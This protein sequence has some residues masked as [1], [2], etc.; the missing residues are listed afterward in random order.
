MTGSE[1]STLQQ[2]LFPSGSPTEDISRSQLLEQYKIFVQTSEA[3]VSRRQTV[4]AF[5][6]SLNTLLL[7]VIGFL[8]KEGVSNIYGGLGVIVMG[9]TG[10]SMA[11]LWRRL[12]RSYNQLNRGKFDVIHILEQHLPAMMFKAEWIVLGEG[13]D[14][15]RYLPSTR[16]EMTIPW[17]FGS[18]YFAGSVGAFAATLEVY[19]SSF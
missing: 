12:I 17:V 9:V 5:F 19:I 8:L 15:T 4:N 18:L 2:I 16:T 1:K 10:I 11:I 6:L 14:K 3:L 7:G 13:A